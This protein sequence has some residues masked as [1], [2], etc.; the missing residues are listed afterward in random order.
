MKKESF[1]SLED[2][3][4]NLKNQAGKKGLAIKDILQILSKQGKLLIILLLTLPFCQPIQ[5]PGFS[6]PFGLSIA[7]IGICIAMER[8]V[9]LPRCISRY[10]VP[11]KKLIKIIDV[12]AICIQK[13]RKW[14][15]PRIQ[16]VLSYKAINSA[17]M[18]VVSLLGICLALPLPI[19]FSNLTAAWGICFIIV[20]SL[21]KDGLFILI[22]YGIFLMT[23]VFLG[24]IAITAINIFS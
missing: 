7:F 2:S 1:S 21:E 20:G 18:V 4:M 13:I 14:I 17:T 3:L 24:V 22:G 10:E 6:T 15:H 11:Q 23:L 5:V 9:W 12:S 16:W 8:P 19:P